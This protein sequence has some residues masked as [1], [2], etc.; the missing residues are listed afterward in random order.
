[1][2]YANNYLRMIDAESIMKEATEVKPRKGLGGRKFDTKSLDVDEDVQN[3]YMQLV[4][5][6]FEDTKKK[7]P[8]VGPEEFEPTE[9]EMA[10]TSDEVTSMVRPRG[11]SQVSKGQVQ[12]EFYESLIEEG[13]PEHV[14]QGMMMN[15]QDESGFNASIVEA[16][17]NVHGTRGKGLIQLTGSRRKQFVDMFGE[18][19]SPKN[20]AKFIAWELFNSEKSAGKKI[21]STSNRNEA[22]QA[23]VT[24]Y[25]RPAEKH[26]KERVARYANS[27]GYVPSTQEG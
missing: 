13:L 17:P 5:S 21:L 27:V 2:N 26:R 22:G 1:M 10:E 9:E 7:M 6:S 19:W 12:Q 16:E 3:K 18:D 4:R 11:R 25:L 8:E 15:A 20:Q 24:H 14:A 23:I